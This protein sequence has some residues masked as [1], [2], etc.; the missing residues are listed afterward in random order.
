MSFHHEPLSIMEDFLIK[1]CYFC[2]IN[3]K[4]FSTAALATVNR[5]SVRV[6]VSVTGSSR[7]LRGET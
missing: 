2:S 5:L 6:C 3:E 1:V 4:D 7:K